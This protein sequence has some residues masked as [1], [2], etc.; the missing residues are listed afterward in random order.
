MGYNRENFVKIKREYEGKKFKAKEESLKR[1]QELYEKIPE[2]TEIDNAL[3]DIGLKMFREALNGKNG[4]QDRVARIKKEDQEA[5]KLRA[6]LL[7]SQGYPTDYTE[8]KYECSECSD[9]G[10]AGINICS[11]MKRAL[12]MAGYESS[13]IAN[14]IKT[15]SFE[16]FNLNYYNDAPNAGK[17]MEKTLKHC[18]EYAEN[19]GGEGENLLLMGPTGLGK[20]HLS[21]SI[22][23]TVIERGYD[24]VYDTAYNIFE[25]FQYERFG[26]TYQD[27]SDDSRDKYF[28]CDLLIM[29]D[30][31]T[32]VINQFTIA[33]MY[34]LINTRLNSKKSMLINT[35]LTRDE[36]RKKYTDRIA[37][38]LFGEFTPRL[39][40]GKDVRESKLR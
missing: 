8:V 26:R 29:D 40:Y 36:I 27:T 19:F 18:R 3:A 1:R 5:R 34:N 9:T 20:T 6:E 30:L 22:A 33:T 28:I 37:S 4:Y 32:E 35:N 7:L 17:D 39:F 13:G 15:Q 38:R 14:L 31:G 23:K 16:T 21:T 25:D 2:L 24:V 10:F 11:C 12:I